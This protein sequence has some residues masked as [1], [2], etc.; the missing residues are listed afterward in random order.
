[1]IIILSAF[2]ALCAGSMVLNANYRRSLNQIF[3][4]YSLLATAWFISVYRISKA[5]TFASE[6][7]Y[8]L[9]WRRLNGS[10]AAFFP[11][12]IWLLK[13]AAVPSFRKKRKLLVDS[14]PWFLLG[15]VLVSLS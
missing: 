9:Y 5:E 1:M 10:L 3:F 7:A 8:D 12:F 15:V 14:W 11:L 13:E 2:V 4:F 6:I